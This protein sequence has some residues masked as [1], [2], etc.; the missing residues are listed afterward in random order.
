MQEIPTG[1]QDFL[2]RLT[3]IV[4]KYLSD[5][6]FG[7]SELAAKAGM[8]RS[9]LLRRIKALTGLSASQFIRQVRLEHAREI[10]AGS[11]ATVSEVSYMVG[12]GS[13][14]YFIKCYREEYGYPPG[15]TAGRI[16]QEQAVAENETPIHTHQ[17]AAIMFTDIQGYTALMQQDEAKAV[18]FRNRHREIFNAAIEKFNGKILQ[19][20][21]D[22]TL[23]TFVSVIDAVKCGIE[24]QLAF[25]SQPK[26]PVR[27]GIHSG[28]IIFTEDDIIGDGVNV[29]S[30]I[31]SLG[32]TGSVF[33]S[34]KVYDEIKNQTGIQTVSMGMFGLK[35]VSKPMEVF[36][37][38]NEGLVVPS[39]E[40]LVGKL[41][42]PSSK[43]N[44]RRSMHPVLTWVLIFIA[45]AATGI[46]LYTTGSFQENQL[47]KA[48]DPAIAEKSIAVLPFIN[49]SDDSSNVYFVNGL[50]E[51]TLND[52]QKIRDIRVVSRTS[53]EKYRNTKRLMPEIGKE[54]NVKYLV[55]GSGQKVGNKV[56]LH[57]QLID[58]ET[59][60]HLW[61][62]QYNREIEDIFAIQMEVA[63]SIAGKIE[64][65]IT[66]EEADRISQVPTQNMV[67]YDHFLKGLDFLNRHTEESLNEAIVYFQKAID[68]DPDF[69]RAYAGAAMAY[70]F[71]DVYRT[72]KQNTREITEYADQALLHDPELAQSLIAKALSFMNKAEYKQAVPYFEKALE[73]NPNS[74]LVI[75]FLSDFYTTFSPD[76]KKY[77]EYS[78]K[79]L[80]L[81]VGAQDS[82]A[83]SYT[84]LHVGNAL[85]QSGFVDE[86]EEH[87]KKSIAYDPTN[88]YPKY[89]LAYIEYA[90]NRD[91][92]A[93]LDELL[94]IFALD[95]TRLDVLQEVAK[96]Y[97]YLRDYQ[98]AYAYYDV[99]DNA[100]KTYRLNIYP[101]EDAKIGMTYDKVG[102]HVEAMQFFDDYLAYAEAD[103]SIYKHMSLS[104]YNAWKGD[105]D[106]ALDQL[107]L[108]SGEEHYQYWIVLFLEMDPLVENLVDLPRFK[109]IMQDIELK[110]WEYHY[111][112]KQNLEQQGLL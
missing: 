39:R 105:T 94:R 112:I 74:S 88:I 29:A 8:S 1:S 53:V 42:K 66:P 50:M 43:E 13:V 5:E 12:F 4:E 24:M 37:V 10:L 72:E 7:V 27:I 57:I 2:K 63:K 47:Y 52:L 17:L 84:Y 99:F 93:T 45:L 46:L 61:S 100:R 73:Y 55:E 82:V 9:N 30:R 77:L 20:Y 41:E 11:G 60:R 26:I 54:L 22:G 44:K 15:E 49:D 75:S 109:T 28:D 86:A 68:E 36:A 90:K 85:I 32:V 92:N 96:T 67:A 104:M 51:S 64:A 23:S 34:E 21:G 58:A 103:K 19:Y 108:F 38:A 18:A 95:T 110:F 101:G 79:G 65:I 111:Q 62:E 91:L 25:T 83:A 87:I 107:E 71:Q 78:L 31:E 81:N 48:A 76:T 59:D 14:S 80:R 33:I 56:L 6:R 89:V 102:K 16:S 3:G 98:T 35:N 69:A 70:Y 40:E 97:Y 106:E